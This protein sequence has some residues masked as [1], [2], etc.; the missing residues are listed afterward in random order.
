MEAD[1]FWA[2]SSQSGW[3]ATKYTEPTKIEDFDNLVLFTNISFTEVLF[4][5]EKKTRSFFKMGESSAHRLWSGILSTDLIY[6]GVSKN[7]GTPKSS[8]L[9]GFSI[10]N[11]PFWG[12]PIF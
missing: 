1:Q 7:D 9:I 3:L 8:I 12:T 6:L 10:I 11:H 5:C 4:S 2:S